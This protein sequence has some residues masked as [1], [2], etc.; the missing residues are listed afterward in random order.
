MYYRVIKS[1]EKV[2]SIEQVIVGDCTVNVSVNAEYK[3]E[4]QKKEKLNKTARE[5]IRHSN[6]N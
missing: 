2:E 3:P 4:K 5:C 6:L 1:N